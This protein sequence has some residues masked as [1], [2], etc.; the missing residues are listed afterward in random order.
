[1]TLEKPHLR[2]GFIALSDC[3]PLAVAKARGLFA[4]EGL[5]VTLSREAS[6][7]NVRDRVAA[8]VLD[9]AHM[10][11]PMAVAQSLGLGGEA[12]PLCVPMALNLNG[13][14]VTVSRAV[15]A[16]MR[17]ADP[18]AAADRP[19]SARA[20]KKV[21]EQ[22]RRAGL[23]PL[24]FGVV[25]PYAIHNYELRDWLA[26]GGVDPERDVRL[27][28]VPPQRMVE[29]L[30]AGEIDGFCVTA[31]WNALAVSR[32]LGEI[33]MFASEWWGAGADKVF[34]VTRRWAQMHPQT[35]QALL[36]A[37]LRA[38]A[39]ADRPENRPELASLLSRPDYVGVSEAVVRESLIAM[40]AIAPG[41]EPGEGADYLVFHRY[42]ASFPWR[43]HAQWFLSQM[44]RWGQAPRDASFARAAAVY[45]PALYREAAV[46]VGA[47]APLA[48]A[49]TEGA[50]RTPWILSGSTGP[51]AM[52][53][54][55][56]ADG[57]VFDPADPLAY[58]DTAPLSRSRP[59]IGT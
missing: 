15:A 40:P 31:P 57:R 58:A 49:K 22:R 33:V 59:T 55:A 35:L 10:L 26:A 1:M 38:A 39:W 23:P 48:D 17:E 11:G 47:A 6:W 56:F 19:R 44:I 18:E 36:R 21:V 29:R 12:T 9:G 24:T 42:A 7:A 28:I 51:I 54:D 13:S 50:H 32:G 37:L 4:N 43:S 16:S 53:A 41:L 14:A 30:A 3:A 52:T 2:L 34:G 5:D 8:G 45:E 27:T 25:F 46:A 20:L